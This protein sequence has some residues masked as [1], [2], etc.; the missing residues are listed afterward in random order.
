MAGKEVFVFLDS[1]EDGF[2]FSLCMCGFC[3]G[4]CQLLKSTAECFRLIL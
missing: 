3:L 1:G 4:F 2:L